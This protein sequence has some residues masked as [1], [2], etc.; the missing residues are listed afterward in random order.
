MHHEQ[1]S[2]ATEGNSLDEAAPLLE[3]SPNGLPTAQTAVPNEAIQLS[4]NVLW[5]MAIHFLLAFCEIILVAPLIK[6]F[7]ASLCLSHYGFPSGGVEESLCKIPDIQRPLATVRG[8]KALF[9]TIP[10]KC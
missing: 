5:F 8:W 10:G 3:H 7:E 6:L 1:Q 4:S 2:P 9:D